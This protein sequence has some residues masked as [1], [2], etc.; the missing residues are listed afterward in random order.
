MVVVQGMLFLV[1]GKLVKVDGK[2]EGPEHKAS[3]KKAFKRL[4]R[5]QV[6]RRGSPSKQE[7]ISK[8][9]ASILLRLFGKKSGFAP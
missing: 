5:T 7:D 3:S 9:I 6:W 1:R 8:H 4:Q 2:K